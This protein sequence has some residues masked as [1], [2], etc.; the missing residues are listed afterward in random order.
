MKI[1]IVGYM[2]SGKTLISKI[3]A[4]KLNE[5]HLDIDELLEKKEGFSI[6]EIFKNK[7]EIYFRKA[8]HNLFNELINSKDSFVL[9]LGGGTP[10]YYDNHE[11]LKNNDVF[12]IYLK[13][14]VETLANRLLNE[15]KTRPLISSFSVA[16]LS[17]YIAK[18]L[19]ERNYFY[20]QSK[21]TINVDSKSP[22][23]VVDEI[24]QLL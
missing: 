2:G 19:F 16:E 12:S 3:L 7:G 11:K 1:V 8:E 20:S 22:D 23:E 24:I 6:K 4:Q 21:Y 13:A 17:E 5:K 15:K 18:H 9:S 10:C 14:N